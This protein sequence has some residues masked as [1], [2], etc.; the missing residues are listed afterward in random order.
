MFQRLH[1]NPHHIWCCARSGWWPWYS[2]KMH[3]NPPPWPVGVL[4]VGWCSKSWGG[5]PKSCPR[6]P[7]ARWG[8]VPKVEVVLQKVV[9]ESP[10]LDGVVGVPKV[11]V[12][13]QNVVP[14]SPRLDRVVFQKFGWC[15]KKLSQNPHS[16]YF[17]IITCN[18]REPS[19]W[20]I[21]SVKSSGL[22]LIRLWGKVVFKV[23]KSYV[24]RLDAQKPP[25][26]S[27]FNTS[28]EC[29]IDQKRFF[30]RNFQ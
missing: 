13:F 19:L 18:I 7:T 16:V 25:D 29:L 20:K 11:G 6:I 2:K 24:D 1:Q 14:E 9:P 21:L 22:S 8:G 10:R 30:H 17:S 28:Y 4:V 5:V 23:E 3:Q 26:F 27:L 15:S 12:V